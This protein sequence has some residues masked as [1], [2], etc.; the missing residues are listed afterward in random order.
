MP[1]EGDRW[2]ARNY[3]ETDKYTSPNSGLHI[4]TAFFL[5]FFQ[6]NER[7][8]FQCGFFVGR[9]GLLLFFFYFSKIL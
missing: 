1:A 7:F 5:L 8:Y 6:E 3:K 2:E 4:A 9:K